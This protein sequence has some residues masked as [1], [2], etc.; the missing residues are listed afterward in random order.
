MNRFFLI[1]ILCFGS[2]LQAQVATIPFEDKELVFIKVEAKLST[3]VFLIQ[4][5]LLQFW[6]VRWQKD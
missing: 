5:L 6:T 2:W 3:T 4:E 1:I